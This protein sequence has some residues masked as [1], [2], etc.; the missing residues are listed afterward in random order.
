[1]TAHN[2]TGFNS[3]GSED[4]VTKITKK[5]AGSDHRLAPTYFSSHITVSVTRQWP[6]CRVH[7]VTNGLTARLS[8]DH[9]VAC[10]LKSWTAGLPGGRGIHRKPL[11]RDS[12]EWLLATCDDRI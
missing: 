4:T 8:H 1:M 11:P 5:M 7:A 9:L 10:G 3:K 12:A 2:N 6:V